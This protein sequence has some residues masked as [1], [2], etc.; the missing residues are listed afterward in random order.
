MSTSPIS[1]SLRAFV[2][3]DEHELRAG[4]WSFGY[5]F[6]LLSGYYILR[7]VRDAMGVAG[8]S[9]HLP[10]MFTAVFLTL[11]AVMPVFGALVARLPR[12]RFVPLVYRFFAGNILVFAALIQLQISPQIVA[13]IFFVWI[14]AYNMF[15]VSVFWSVMADVFSSEQGK[16]LFGFI[17]AGGSTGALIG[18]WLTAALAERVGLGLLLILSAAFLEAS[19]RCFYRVII[20]AAAPAHAMPAATAA[21]TA[22][23][24]PAATATQ[25]AETGVIGGSILAGLTQV[26][27][28]PYLLG[29]CVYLLCTSAAATFLYISRAEI[30]EVAFAGNEVR[31]AF[32]AIVDAL[33]NLL[34]LL[35]Q[36]LITARL[37]T[38]LGVAVTL[39]ILPALTLGGFAAL[40]AAPALAV[41]VAF[42]VLMRSLRYAVAR[43]G[44]EMLFTVVSREQ[45]YK[46]KN[47]IDTAVYRGG[48]AV[49]SWL[50]RSLQ[51]FGLTLAGIALAIM[52][53]MVAWLVVAVLLGRRQSVLAQRQQRAA[54]VSPQPQS[55]T[56]V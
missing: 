48:D 37:L 23:V 11:L 22:T 39:A 49:S 56:I 27:R 20:H 5:F 25:T 14:T 33:T 29:V 55:A 54:P 21:S 32:F 12:R 46:C 10:W 42:Q 35:L 47:F 6:C 28:S 15:V 13:Q 53:L 40:S 51:A 31:S 30:V 18:S 43:P 38:W 26:M 50:L 36:L 52:P 16:R 19:A 17:A 9:H 3:A 34:T 7:P 45:K 1:K 41:L 44:R 8:G 4:L 24:A 2:S